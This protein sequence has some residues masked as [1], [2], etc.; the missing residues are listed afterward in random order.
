MP[1]EF[2]ESLIVK[3]KGMHDTKTSVCMCITKYVQVTFSLQTISRQRLQNSW[4]AAKV[5]SF[6]KYLDLY[7]NRLHSATSLVDK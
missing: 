4:F 7:N 2:L 5:M 1:A 6:Y 3:Q